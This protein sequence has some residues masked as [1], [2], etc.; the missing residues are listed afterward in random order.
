[1]FLL[2]MRAALKDDLRCSTAELVYGA[3]LHLTGELSSVFD[4][5]LLNVTTYANQLNMA[6][7]GFQAT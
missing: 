2:G 3:L 1:M 7:Q 5:T 4:D 6:M